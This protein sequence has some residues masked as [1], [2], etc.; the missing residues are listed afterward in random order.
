[1][2]INY[3]ISEK[4]GGVLQSKLDKKNSRLITIE[5]NNFEI[6]LNLN[7][8]RA[9]YNGLFIELSVQVHVGCCYDP[10]KI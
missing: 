8:I 10:W 6:I 5:I 3:G 2:M 4:Y 9:I 1:M 7:T